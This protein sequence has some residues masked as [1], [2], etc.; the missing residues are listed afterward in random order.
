M[1]SRGACS[2]RHLEESEVPVPSGCMITIPE[3]PPFSESIIPQAERDRSCAS[4]P[5]NNTGKIPGSEDPGYNIRSDRG[6]C[7]RLFEGRVWTLAQQIFKLN[8][9]VG[10]GVAVLDDYRR[11]ERNSPIFPDA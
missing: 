2:G 7:S 5:R 11:V 1:K 8:L 9:G 4:S 10:F 6:C 3:V